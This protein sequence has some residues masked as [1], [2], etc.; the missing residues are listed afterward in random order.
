MQDD[1]SKPTV[2]RQLTRQLTQPVLREQT[3]ALVRRVPSGLWSL[4]FVFCVWFPTF[5]AA[6]WAVEGW[7]VWRS[8]IFVGTTCA[9][10]GYGNISPATDGGK[11]LVMLCGV[12]G[13]PCVLQG[14]SFCGQT[15]LHLV[16]TMLRRCLRRTAR[17]IERSVTLVLTSAAF[18]AHCIPIYMAME[19]WSF[20]DALYYTFVCFSTI[21]FGDLVPLDTPEDMS[22][23]TFY[24]IWHVVVVVFGLSLLA[25]AFS[26][27]TASVE[28]VEDKLTRRLSEK[29]AVMVPVHVAR[30]SSRL[31]SETIDKTAEAAPRAASDDDGVPPPGAQQ[32][33]SSHGA[34]QQSSSPVSNQDGPVSR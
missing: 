16:D 19:N 2:L 4:L 10:V 11:L 29:A 15:W 26:L 21:G 1:P 27:M 9:T 34:Q 17:P 32:Q 3:I 24:H 18:Y 28:A 13:I 14:L 7:P 12:V 31:R 8:F 6:F 22:P 30:F 20:V 33:S 5:T 25:A 23:I